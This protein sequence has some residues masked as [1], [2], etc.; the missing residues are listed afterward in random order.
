MAKK[1]VKK[2]TKKNGKATRIKVWRY[3]NFVLLMV[4]FIVFA[5]IIQAVSIAEVAA[6]VYKVTGETSEL[7]SLNRDA[8]TEIVIKSNLSMLNIVLIVSGA[9]ALVH[10]L[11]YFLYINK[12]NTALIIA[13]M[14]EVVVCTIGVLSD[15][16]IIPFICGICVLPIIS[17]FMYLRI[18]KLEEE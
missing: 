2:S 13:L 9:Y 8:F 10:V 15:I 3:A 6:G 4:S 11:N 1:S 12:R 7:I 5:E 16:S 18:L 17:G 14:V